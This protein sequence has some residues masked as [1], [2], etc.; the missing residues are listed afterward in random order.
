MPCQCATCQPNPGCPGIKCR[1]CAVHPQAW[2]ASQYCER[3]YLEGPWWT[4]QLL[5]R[6]PSPSLGT[7]LCILSISVAALLVC[8]NLK[9]KRLDFCVFA[10]KREEGSAEASHGAGDAGTRLLS[11]LLTEMDGLEHAT[12]W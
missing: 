3:A 4:S 10:G 9:A 5:Q 8:L 11:T 7:E 6:Q 2:D 12:G 1:P